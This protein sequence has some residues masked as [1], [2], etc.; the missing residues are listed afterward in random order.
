VQ[1]ARLISTE[2]PYLE[3]KIEVEGVCL[4]VMDAFSDEKNSLRAGAEIEIEF[5]PC[6]SDEESWEDI[7]SGSSGEKI[8]FEHLGGWAYRAFGK[9]LSINPVF[10]DCGLIKV[11]DVVQTN[12]DRVIGEFVAFTISRLDVYVYPT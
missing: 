9:I 4:H 12:D 3:A 10:V 6:L 2:G 7:F 1:L 5:S 8:G 11:E